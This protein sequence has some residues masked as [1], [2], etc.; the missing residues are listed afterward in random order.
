MGGRPNC[1]AA[2]PAMMP[3]KARMPP[4]DRSNMPAI[5]K[6]IMPQARIPVC[7]VSSSTTAALAGRMN[8]P[9]LE[10]RHDDQERRDEQD[11]EARSVGRDLDQDLAP[12]RA[13][14][15][16]LGRQAALGRGRRVGAHAAPC[17]ILS[18]GKRG[19][20]ENGDLRR[21]RR[22]RVRRRRAGRTSRR[23]GAPSA[24]T[25]GRSDETTSSGEALRREVAQNA[26]DVGLGADVDAARRLVDDQNARRA[27]QPFGQHHLLLVAAR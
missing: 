17:R 12:P 22:R 27:R 16:G 1:L 13:A 3:E 8:V 24:S 25:S 4:I 18:R 9:R 15:I 21:A 2:R 19:Q 10:H 23:C 5:I 6:T 20:F 14:R 7:A 11:Q 26:I